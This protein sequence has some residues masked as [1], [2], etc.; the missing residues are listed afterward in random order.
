MSKHGDTGGSAGD[1]GLRSRVGYVVRRFNQAIRG[2]VENGL[3]PLGLTTSQYAVLS[4]LERQG[5][6]NNT[7]IA[8]ALSVTPQTMTRILAGLEDAGLIVR[9]TS[10]D[11][12]RVRLARLTAEGAELVA[13]AHP[14]VDAAEDRLFAPLSQA[15]RM[16]LLDNMWKCAEALPGDVVFDGF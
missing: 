6:A 4:L 10:G 3:R 15:Q 12:A 16:E 2:Q 8:Q 5:V 13:R 14:V 11:H 1:E 9:D 7:R